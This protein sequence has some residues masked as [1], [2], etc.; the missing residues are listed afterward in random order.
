LYLV[1][2]VVLVALAGC[3]HSLFQTQSREPWR[4]EAELTCLKSGS[5]K[6]SP[7]LVRI[8]PIEG[9]GQCGADFPLKVAALGSSSSALGFADDPR[10]PGSIPGGGPSPTLRWQQGPPPVTANYPGRYE[11]AP[12]RGYSPAG[13]TAAPLSLHAPGAE[14]VIEEDEAEPVQP[15]RSAPPIASTPPRNAPYRDASPR[16][17][18]PRDSSP[19]SAPSRDPVLQREL[20]RSAP[21]REESDA[22]RF[23]SPQGYPPA[24]L[25][26]RNDTLPL[27]RNLTTASIGPAALKPAATLACPIVSALEDW[28]NGSVQPAA[29][30]WFGQPVVEIKQI[31]AY[32]CRGMNGQPGAHISEH[33]FGNALD[34]AGFILADGRKVIVEKAWN[35]S[36][37]EQGFL[38]DVQGGACERFTTVLAPGSNKYHYNHIHVDLMRRKTGRIICQPKAIPGDVVAARVAEKRGLVA[39]RYDPGVTGSIKSRA[40]KTNA[41]AKFSTKHDSF[42]NEDD[43]WVEDDGPRPSPED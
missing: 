32:S 21:Q 42:T 17:A 3:G 2:S 43:D 1:G 34:V 27:S 11:P 38:H 6:E 41:A 35:A 29:L 25:A 33:A 28:M 23:S 31:S 39:G 24:Q 10:P 15:G 8:S 7:A 9:P 22:Q 5:V 13:N 19:R 30:R 37:E 12:T 36:P 18:S 20:E 40:A 26:P 16:D 14:D 4:H